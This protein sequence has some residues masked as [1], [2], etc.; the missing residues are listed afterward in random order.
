MLSYIYFTNPVKNITS[1]KLPK[2]D[3]LSMK[4]MFSDNALVCYKPG[5]LAPGGTGTVSNSR[6][7]SRKT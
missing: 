4:S 6:L 7:K 5:S 1:N 3:P 2:T